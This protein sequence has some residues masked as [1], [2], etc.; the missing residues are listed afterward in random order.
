MSLLS[1][2]FLALAV[3]TA[4]AQEASPWAEGRELRTEELTERL[5]KIGAWLRNMDSRRLDLDRLRSELHA[6]SLSEANLA[7]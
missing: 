5:D 4:P 2:V 3:T 1:I 7:E 6:P